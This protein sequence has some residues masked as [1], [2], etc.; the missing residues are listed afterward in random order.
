MK[1]KP[2][3]KSFIPLLPVGL[4]LMW[5]MLNDTLSFGQGV[6]G[7]RAK[8]NASFGNPPFYLRPFV[9]FRGVAAL[10]YPGETVA[11]FEAEYRHPL[12][13]P[14][15]ALVFAGSGQARSDF[16]GIDVNNTVSAGGVGVRY[17]AA[18][19]FGLTLGVD[20]AH[21]PDGLVTYIQIGNAWTN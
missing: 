11:S 9:S 10:R 7:L 3:P 21:G 2:K 8:G 1:L 18:K 6:L 13:G 17:K 5:L 15:H 19:L 16:R 12:R 14:W 4:V 20:A